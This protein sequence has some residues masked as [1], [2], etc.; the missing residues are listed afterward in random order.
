MIVNMSAYTLN[1]GTEK[2]AVAFVNRKSGDKEE[3]E[4]EV[5]EGNG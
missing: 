1:S 4:D 3:E 5:S 2:V